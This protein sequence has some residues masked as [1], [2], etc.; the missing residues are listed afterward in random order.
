M[1]LVLL[2]GLDGS[3]E[4]FFPL[5]EKLPTNIDSLVIKYPHDYLT[6]REL[7]LYVLAHIPKDED[8]ILVAESFSGAVGY[9]I[10]LMKPQRLK[11]IVFVATFLKTPKAF[12]MGLLLYTPLK[13]L[14]YLKLPL[15][16]IRYFLIGFDVENSIVYKTKNIVNAIPKRILFHRLITIYH[17]S[18]LK[19]K[20]N[21]IKLNVDITYIEAEHDKL[22]DSSHLKDFQDTFYTV[23]DFKLNGSHLLL[24]SNAFDTSAII[25]KIISTSL[26]P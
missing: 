26:S 2:A 20:N 14:L 16:I 13:N 3:G 19:R 23:Q 11:H 15:F 1:K 10:A 18:Y 21:I 22:I 5:L 4:L 25:S 9:E 12:L 7:A 8:F 24:K 6:Y 17:L